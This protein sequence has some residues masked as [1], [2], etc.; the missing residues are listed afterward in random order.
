MPT[1]AQ[2]RSELAPVT[3]LLG[4]YNTGV[5][6]LGTAGWGVWRSGLQWAD[7][8]GEDPRAWWAGSGAEGAMCPPLSNICC[9]CFQQRGKKGWW[10][11]LPRAAQLLTAA[12]HPRLT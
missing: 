11:P 1:A 5:P 9:L 8:Y 3:A 2:K 7:D 6:E 10:E 4:L 12:Q